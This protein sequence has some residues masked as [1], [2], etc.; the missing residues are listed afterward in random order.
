MKKVS[1][2]YVI[3]A[4]EARKKWAGALVID[5]TLGGAMEKMDPGFPLGR[6]EV[7]GWK[8]WKT[9]LSVMG[10]WEGLKVFAK[11]DVDESYFSDEKKLGKSRGCKSYGKLLGVKIGDEVMDVDAAVKEVFVKVFKETVA[12]RMGPVLE[13]LREEAGKRP[14][15]LLDYAEGKEKYPVSHVELL[16]EM[17]EK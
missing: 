9:S 8:T 10:M 16:K 11:K 7:P 6:I 2:N 12:D 13:T 1:D 17:I 3:N 14:V 5:P 4:K 15:V